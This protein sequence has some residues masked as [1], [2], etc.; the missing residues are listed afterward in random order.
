MQWSPHAPASGAPGT[1]CLSPPQLAAVGTPSCPGPL[2]R[3][4]TVCLSAALFI[5]LLC[6]REFSSWQTAALADFFSHLGMRVHTRSMP[7]SLASGIPEAATHSP[8]PFLLL[9]LR[10]PGGHPGVW[11]S[12]GE[13]E[14]SSASWKLPSALGEILGE[15]RGICGWRHRGLLQSRSS[16][17][18][19]FLF[20]Y[21]ATPCGTR[22]SQF[23][24]Q[25]LGSPCSC[26]GRVDS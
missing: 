12:S 7:G 2:P 20:F 3:D 5:L 15:L 26:S 11:G 24:G 13:A 21:L 14:P 22:E 19:S 10:A 16:I 4:W 6:E 9:P 1:T 8:Q 17:H 25:G 18:F 23:P